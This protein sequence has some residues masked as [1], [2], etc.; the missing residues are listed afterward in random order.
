VEGALVLLAVLAC[1]VGMGLMMWF[2]SKGMRG[3]RSEERKA[4]ST[5]VEDLR[6][7]QARLAAEI[8]Q[9]EQNGH[10][11]ANRATGAPS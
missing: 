10:R 11:E 9:L 6:R 5:S 1:P 3:G 2:M 4:D 8:D 7:E